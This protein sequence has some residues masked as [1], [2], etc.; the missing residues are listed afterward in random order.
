M[1][2]VSLV[3]SI[4]IKMNVSLCVARQLRVSGRSLGALLNN[5]LWAECF[6]NIRELSGS[7]MNI[8]ELSII[9]TAGV[10]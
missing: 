9:S 2:A 8:V 4:L 3:I 1:L 10:G 6:S 5:L 7:G